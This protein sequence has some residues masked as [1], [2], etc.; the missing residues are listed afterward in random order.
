MQLHE[1]VRKSMA[2]HIRADVYCKAN[3]INPIATM[4]MTKSMTKSLSNSS[5]QLAGS[6]NGRMRADR[7]RRILAASS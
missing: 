7:C 4:S 2:E 1:F 5:L 6:W 3:T